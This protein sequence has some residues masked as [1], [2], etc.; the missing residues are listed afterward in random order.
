MKKNPAS[1]HFCFKKENRG[2]MQAQRK[3]GNHE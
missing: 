1:Q 3:T 2:D